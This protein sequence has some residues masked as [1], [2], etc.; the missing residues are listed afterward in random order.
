MELFKNKFD[1]CG[2]EACANVCNKG[3]ISIQEDENG[4]RYPHIDSHKCIDCG[5]C[6]KVCAYQNIEETNIAKD[7]Y[8]AASKDEEQI[9]K[10]ASGGIFAVIAK[11]IISKGG[12]VCGSALT[13]K[14]NK[15]C[16]EHIL[17]DNIDDISKLQG[18]KYVQS[19]INNCYKE[20]K[21]HLSDGRTVLFS[22]TPCQCAGLK[23]FLR[24]PYNNLFIIDIICH[25]VPNQRFLNDYIEYKH[26]S[27]TEICNFSFRDKTKGW[28]LTGRIDYEDG[29]SRLI[30][31]GLSSYYSLFLDSQI[32]R[33][34]C[35]K[36]KYASRNRPGDITL[37]DYWG[38]QKEHPELLSTGRY[39]PKNGISCIIVNTDKGNTILSVVSDM[40]VKDES[41]YEKVVNRNTQLVSPSKRGKHYNTIF[42]L[43]SKEGYKSIDKFFYNHYKKQIF[44]HSVLSKFPF[45]VRALIQKILK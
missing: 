28:G 43:Y 42:S 5:L 25:G 4:F 1:C 19:N 17:I 6:Q 13:V 40:I 34:N 15:V 31:A 27:K 36:C 41:S 29:S 26:I 10:S 18:S 37:G 22:G 11:E 21:Q 38:I 14:D 24:K 32:Y 2:C 39:N 12:I 35:Y 45:K 20:I 44:I 3:A 7:V 16:V 33:E 30:P 9:I 23:G 8:V